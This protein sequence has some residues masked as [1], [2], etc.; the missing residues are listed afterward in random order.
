MTRSCKNCGKEFRTVPSRPKNIYCSGPCKHVHLGRRMARPLVSRFWEK[1]SK[2]GPIIMDSSC[3]EWTAYRLP[4]GYGLFDRRL[5]HRISW[6][7]SRG[8]IP[9]GL[10]VCHKCD[11]P[12]CVNPDHLFVGTMADNMRD[13]STKGRFPGPKNLPVCKR[14][15]AYD[16]KNTRHYRGAKS[17]RKCSTREFR[18]IS[19]ME[20]RERNAPSH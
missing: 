18:A 14:G 20:K 3:W 15:H 12:P 11:H 16:E 4:H 8:P 7:L 19:A 2:R 9:E 6:E 13:R 17:C 5:A 1:V 10:C